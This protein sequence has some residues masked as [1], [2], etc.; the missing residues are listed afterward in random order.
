MTSFDHL[1]TVQ[2]QKWHLNTQFIV[3]SHP[4]VILAVC[5]PGPQHIV[6][7]D[8]SHFE[9]ICTLSAVSLINL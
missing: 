4:E 3:F 9:G 7:R 8:C 1:N 2:K 6:C 5:T